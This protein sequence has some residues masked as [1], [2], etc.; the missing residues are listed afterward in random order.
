[1][2]QKLQRFGGAMFTPVLLFAFSGIILS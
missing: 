2:M 1:M